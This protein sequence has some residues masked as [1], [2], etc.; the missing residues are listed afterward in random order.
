MEGVNDGYLISIYEIDTYLPELRSC[1]NEGRGGRPGL[2]VPNT[3]VVRTV[4]LVVKQ[5]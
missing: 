4:S 5:H 1:V 3:V 2:L